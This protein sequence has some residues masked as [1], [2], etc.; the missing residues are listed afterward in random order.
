MEMMDIFWH[1][2]AAKKLVN[3]YLQLR[4]R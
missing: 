3:N 4:A 1:P 2:A